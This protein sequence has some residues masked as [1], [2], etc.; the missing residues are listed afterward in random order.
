MAQRSPSQTIGPFFHEGLRWKDG[1]RVGFASSG[2]RIVLTG[3]ILDGAGEPVGD[4]LIETWQQTPKASAAAAEMDL[5]KLPQGTDQGAAPVKLPTSEGS[6]PTAL[7]PL[8]E[9]A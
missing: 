2:E 6:T 3:R 5:S 4:A 7:P 9:P 8:S 1:G